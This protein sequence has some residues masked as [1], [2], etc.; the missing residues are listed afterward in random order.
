LVDEDRKV[1]NRRGVETE[2][3][4]FLLWQNALEREHDILSDL[5][6]RF[7]V[8]DVV[9]V[10]WTP[11]RFSEN[12]SR[13][14]RDQLPPGSDK[15]RH[16]GTGPFRLIVVQDRHPRYRKRRTSGGSIVANRRVFDARATYRRWTG[17]GHRIHASVSRGEADHDLFLLL[18]VRAAAYENPPATQWDGVIASQSRDLLGAEGWKSP[19]ELFTAF[20]VTFDYALLSETEHPSLPVHGAERTFEILVHDSWWAAVTANALPSNDDGASYTAR[21][22]G[23]VVQLVL[24]DRESGELDPDW[25]AD[26][27]RRRIRD[28]SG[29][30]VSS[31]LDA[32]HLGIH[33]AVHSGNAIT[34]ERA[35]DLRVL[36]AQ[37]GLVAA[38]LRD[39]A[40]AA[41][42]LERFFRMQGYRPA[43]P[44]A[45]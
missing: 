37:H 2:V 14:Y 36:A 30:F 4:V 32:L 15:E 45:L 16:C 39:P 23:R 11:E 41:S 5:R 26:I 22:G 42:A 29:V 9:D 17:G 19:E 10:E 1:W 3:Q 25:Q 33:A 6:R 7:V 18:G 38:D 13:F 34:E 20:E 43:Q 44:R 27:L 24:R 28:R 35:R 40:I 8:L 21:V 12:L 31:P